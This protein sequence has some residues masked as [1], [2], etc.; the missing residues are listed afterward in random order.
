MIQIDQLLYYMG[1]FCVHSVYC[2]N[3][4]R[5]SDFSKLFACEKRI[6]SSEKQVKSK[7]PVS[8]QIMSHTSFCLFL[9]ERVQRG[10]RHKF[11]FVYHEG[12][13]SGS[14]PT[15]LCARGQGQWIGWS[16]DLANSLFLSF[17]LTCK[18]ALELSANSGANVVLNHTRKAN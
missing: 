13:Y 7:L 5:W 12:W 15:I 16:H 2:K 4:D 17:S 8:S 11:L 10:S 18:H 3:Q 14:P 1:R 9:L 6:L